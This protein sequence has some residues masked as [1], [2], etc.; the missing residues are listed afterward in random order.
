LQ[1]RDAVH[2]RERR[3][4]GSWPRRPPLNCRRIR[5]LRALGW[6]P[7][8]GIQGGT[9]GGPSKE[10]RATSARALALALRYGTKLLVNSALSR[11]VPDQLIPGDTAW[12]TVA[13][14]HPGHPR[15][16]SWTSIACHHAGV[17]VSRSGRC[18]LPPAA[19][20]SGAATVGIRGG[21]EAL[22]RGARCRVADRQHHH[23]HVTHE[24]ARRTTAADQG[25]S[26]QPR[27]SPTGGAWLASVAGSKI[28]NLITNFRVPL[29]ILQKMLCNLQN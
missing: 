3:R 4:G 6:S 1:R 10:S 12:T 22:L 11:P 20:I 23:G 28:V 29:Q 14:A 13:H 17:R 2:S 25:G 26:R 18:A 24:E 19:M 27:S 21:A 8:Q 5:M 9:V 7:E 16:A 15:R